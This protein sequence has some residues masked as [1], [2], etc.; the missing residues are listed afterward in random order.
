MKAGMNDLVGSIQDGLESKYE[1]L[2]ARCWQE[3]QSTIGTA[4]PESKEDDIRKLYLEEA[5]SL[6]HR[7]DELKR[8]CV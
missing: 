2:K 1:D 4:Q 3:L 5:M 6:H 8:S 7:L